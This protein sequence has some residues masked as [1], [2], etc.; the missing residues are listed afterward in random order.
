MHRNGVGFTPYLREKLDEDA[1]SAAALVG[2]V[3]AALR[4][5]AAT[6]GGGGGLGGGVGVG[7]VAHGDDDARD[8]W[9]GRWKA[10]SSGR[11]HSSAASA[12]R[13]TR[14]LI[15]S[16]SA[17]AALDMGDPPRR[18]AAAGAK[19]RKLSGGGGGLQEE[20]NGGAR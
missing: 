3:L 10:S 6:G 11:A 12:W 7:V 19:Q 16:E 5:G 1:I 9:E 18:S 4:R 8:H 2:V 20:D 13:T 15:S 17:E 14:A